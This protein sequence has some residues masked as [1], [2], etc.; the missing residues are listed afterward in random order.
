ML[1]ERKIEAV[2]TGIATGSVLGF[3]RLFRQQALIS[4][5]GRDDRERQARSALGDR[6]SGVQISPPHKG[7]VTAG[8]VAVPKRG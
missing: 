7:E 8:Y 6:G 2:A 1:R 5:T 3:T 4:S